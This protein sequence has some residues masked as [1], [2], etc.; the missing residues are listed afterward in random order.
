M[1]IRLISADLAAEFD[2]ILFERIQP[3]QGQRRCGW[4]QNRFQG[5]PFRIPCEESVMLLEGNATAEIDGERFELKPQ[6]TTFIPANLPHR[7]INASQTERMK[8]LRIDASVGATRTLI[9]TGDTR[10]IDAEHGGALARQGL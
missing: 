7:F 10:P 8:I 6:D 2:G 1:R 5:E 4:A 9:A 3:R